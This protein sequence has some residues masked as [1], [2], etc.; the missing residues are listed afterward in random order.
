M[1]DYAY[2]AHVR[3]GT[4]L[5]QTIANLELVRSVALDLSVAGV[6]SKIDAAAAAL[7]DKENYGK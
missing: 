2:T 3:L 7:L 1:A 6:S 5:D 4:T